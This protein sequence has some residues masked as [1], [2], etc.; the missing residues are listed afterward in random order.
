[1]EL[2]LSPVT[3]STVDGRGPTPAELAARCA[4]RIVYV[5]DSAPPA[6][7]DQA[8]AFQSRVEHVILSYMTQVADQERSRIARE[9]ELTGQYDAA[10]VVR[11]L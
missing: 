5:G 11:D 10:K 6:I 7:R 1:M 3:V 8:R 4:Q 2:T 9:L